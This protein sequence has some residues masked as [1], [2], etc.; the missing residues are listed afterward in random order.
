[1]NLAMRILWTRF[2]LVLLARAGRRASAPE[3]RRPGRFRARRLASAAGAVARGA[4][5][6]RAPT[7]SCG[8]RCCFTSGRSGAGSARSTREMQTLAAAR[9]RGSGAVT[10]GA[11]HLHPCGVVRGHGDWLDSRL[12]RRAR[13]LCC[14]AAA[15]R[16]EERAEVRRR[17]NLMSRAPPSNLQSYR[18]TASRCARLAGNPASNDPSPARHRPGTALPHSSSAPPAPSRRSHRRLANRLRAAGRPSR[19]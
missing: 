2:V 4:A 10:A 3:G 5:A 15:E 16:A 6:D 13:R 18:P 19:D 14:G 12:A 9:T 8:S 11:L 17:F 7:R 1:M